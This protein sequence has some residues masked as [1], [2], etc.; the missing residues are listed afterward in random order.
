MDSPGKGKG[1]GGERERGG[2][3]EREGGVFELILQVVE[4]GGGRMRSIVKD[5]KRKSKRGEKTSLYTARQ[6]FADNAK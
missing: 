4:R 6:K 2:R 5:E 1:G 3:G